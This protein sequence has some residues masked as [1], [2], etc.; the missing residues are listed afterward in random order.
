MDNKLTSVCLNFTS[1]SQTIVDGYE[2]VSKYKFFNFD[3]F[4]AYFKVPKNR[5]FCRECLIAYLVGSILMI[6]AFIYQRI[7]RNHHQN[8][9]QIQ[10]T[11]RRR[12]HDHPP[13]K[14]RPGSKFREKEI[15]VAIINHL[16]QI[17]PNLF[18]NL[19]V[20]LEFSQ[21]GQICCIPT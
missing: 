17:D 7:D 19:N 15:R 1:F 20:K 11:V 3:T 6:I 9:I 13:R 5:L 21:D 10:P 2:N 12:V 4:H 16:K 18:K 14:R 8:S